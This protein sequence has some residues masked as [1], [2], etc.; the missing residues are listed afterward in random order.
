VFED[1]ACGFWEG[2]VV[3]A[4][5]GGIRIRVRAPWAT[6][7][8]FPGSSQVVNS[9]TSKPLPRLRVSGA[10]PALRAT[11]RGFAEIVS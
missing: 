7:Q 1:G 2:A 11:A 6:K 10:T 4:C 9:R 5:F 8:R 3:G